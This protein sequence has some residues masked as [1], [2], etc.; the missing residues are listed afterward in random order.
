M[1]DSEIK[2]LIEIEK[3]ITE[4]PKDSFILKQGSLR[5]DFNLES[6]VN[7]RKFHAFI[8]INETFSEDFSIGLVYIN[9]EGKS[10]CIVRC[11]GKHYHKNKIR[12]NDNLNDFH[13][14]IATEDAISNE[15]S[16][17]Q[18]AEV[19]QSYATWQDALSYFCKYVNIKGADKYFPNLNQPSLF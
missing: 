4:G 11:N 19:T 2:E 10:I 8:R 14:H 6:S 3:I 17:E 1:K 16:P 18:Y 15:L 7:S 9:G 13:V 5:N 12:N